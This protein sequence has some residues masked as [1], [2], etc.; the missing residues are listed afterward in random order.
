MF[1]LDRARYLLELLGNPQDRLKII[2]VAGSKGKGSTCAMTASVLRAAGYKVGLYTSPHLNNC[3]ERI[4]V[5]DPLHPP[6][7]DEEDIFQDMISEQELCATLEVIKPRAA[8][9]HNEKT[10]GELSFFELFTALA[11]YHFHQARVDW[12]V[13]ETGMGGRLDATNVASSKICVITPISLEHTQYLGGTIAKIAGE[14]AAIIKDPLA[15]VVIA[16]QDPAARDVLEKRCV[17]FSIRPIWIGRDIRYKVLHA[18]A[19][20]GLSLQNRLRQVVRIQRTKQHYIDFE[21]SL[22]GRHQAINA[23]VVL[24]IVEAL[25]GMDCV[26]SQEAVCAGLRDTFWPGRLEVIGQDPVVILDCAHNQ[27]SAMNL[28]ESLRRIFPNRSATLILGVSQDK[29]KTGICR[30]LDSITQTVIAAKADHPRAH[31]FTDDELKHFFPGK[32]FVR[33]ADVGPAI[34]AAC[35]DAV[36]ENI[37]LIAG[38]VFLVSE[39]RRYLKNKVVFQG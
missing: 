32:P 4:R 29:D 13:L 5:L 11:F 19:G 3:R 22:P 34:E 7:A 10:F 31:R 38:S 30:E 27:A 37:I 26:V 1:K 25:Q 16:P 36:P 39:A 21:L 9:L 14:K 6:S 12:V 17:E 24:G 23:A 18:G 8:R 33:I 15:K 20:P 35:R 28:V 2:H